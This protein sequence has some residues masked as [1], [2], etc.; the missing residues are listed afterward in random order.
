MSTNN[1]PMFQCI[2]SKVFGARQLARYAHFLWKSLF[3]V[4]RKE[5]GERDTRRAKRQIS[6][7]ITSF[8][9]RNPSKIH[10]DLRAL[11]RF[12]Y[13]LGEHRSRLVGKSL[14]SFKG[15]RIGLF[16]E[17]T[18]IRSF[19]SHDLYFVNNTKISFDVNFDVEILNHHHKT[20]ESLAIIN[21]TTMAA[22]GFGP[23]KGKTPTSAASSSSYYQQFK[24]IVVTSEWYFLPEGVLD[25]FNR[26]M[27]SLTERNM[28]SS[29]CSSTQLLIHHFWLYFPRF[30]LLPSE[31][32]D[33]K[34]LLVSR[35]SEE[36]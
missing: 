13:L 15:G 10:S 27:T 34:A 22:S 20:R 25:V 23:R 7:Y 30:L 18:L 16:D 26:F 35:R 28:V 1:T 19:P 31:S 14:F 2:D 32:E 12:P 4:V 8:L 24:D 21:N 11:R 17:N 6:K 9:V 33:S 29:S 3:C 36:S 5:K